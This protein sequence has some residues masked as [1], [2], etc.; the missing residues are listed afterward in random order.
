MMIGTF[1]CR[2]CLERDGIEATSV[3]EHR[4]TDERTGKHFA[5]SVC[6]RCL[7]AGRETRVTCRTFG[8]RIGSGSLLSSLIVAVGTSGLMDPEDPVWAAIDSH[9]EAYT[10]LDRALDRQEELERPILASL[11]AYDEAE[12]LD[13]PRWISFRSELHTLHEAEARAAA[14][15]IRCVPSTASGAT[16]RTQY[17]ADL[18]GRGY[19]WADAIAPFNLQSR[20]AS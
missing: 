6:V 18:A 10:D 15:L 20:S 19:Q 1:L 11:G 7:E 13:D 12:L 5:A 17:I 4:C 8:K 14:S 3:V 16:A 2:V 9:A